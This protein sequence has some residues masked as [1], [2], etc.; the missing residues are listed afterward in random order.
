MGSSGT[1][2]K[3]KDLINKGFDKTIFNVSNN[4]AKGNGVLCKLQVPD[5][6]NTLTALIT[7]ASIIGKNEIETK[8]QIEF[9]VNNNNYTIQID[10]T[11]KTYVNEETYNLSIVEIK[12]EDGL[13]VDS[14]L[15]VELENLEKL[16]KNDSIGVIIYNNKDKKFEFKNVKIKKKENGYDIEYK[17][18]VNEEYIGCPIYDMKN[19]K[20]LGLHK[21]IKSGN[22]LSLAIKDFFEQEKKK[23][24]ENKSIYNS[25]KK[26]MTLKSTLKINEGKLN[27]E[28]G[29]LYAVPNR[30]E[31][32]KIFGED[33]VKNNKDK[34]KLI[35]YDNEEDKEYE[36]DLC[37]Y[38]KMDF[39][40]QINSG[41]KL[42]KI[43]LIQTD[44]FTDMSFMF[45]ECFTLM[46]VENIENLNTEKVTTM[47]GMF[48]SCFLLLEINISSLN[49]SS[50]T[51]MSF[52]FEKC[53]S[54]QELDFTGWKTTKVESFKAM[55]EHCEKLEEIKG[56]ETWDVSNVK[57][58]SFMFNFCKS[59]SN[60][61]DITNWNTS[62]FLDIGNM[63]K[64][65]TS[66]ENL[67]DISRWDT[68]NVKSFLAIFAACPLIK[69]LPDISNWNME[70][71]ENISAMFSGCTSLKKLPDIS[72]WNISKVT[73]MK[74]LFTGCSSLTSMPD[75]SIWN[76]SNVKI[77]SFVFY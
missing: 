29:I 72:K 9:S 5:S 22:L 62:S 38:L 28:I 65:L 60:I 31:V 18:K 46:S 51:D 45:F 75:I 13:D 50:V 24:S 35:L 12:R 25:L 49:T 70:S 57:D 40:N 41:R 10:N 71:A 11:R 36:Y 3:D 54:I 69:S 27:N 43:F 73:N 21:T 15:E 16:D 76:T 23:E 30:T 47:S 4:A 42:F 20:V 26:T 39:V 48:E 1:K 55:F 64:G 58:C 17:C 32:I 6:K 67:P 61:S 66:M 2:V 19:N 33:F 37:A 53:Q 52:M 7:Y 63:F 34:C 44:Y 8:K 68:K 59:L 56:L 77:M 74:S 14:F